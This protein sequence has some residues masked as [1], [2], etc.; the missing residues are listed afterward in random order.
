M[1][2]KLGRWLRTAGY[3]TRIADIGMTDRQVMDQAVNEQR[4]LITRD[5]KMQEYREARHTVVLLD[6]AEMDD[7]IEEVTQKLKINW[8]LKPFSRC[9]KCN[10]EL[11]E[12]HPD[13][14]TQLPEEVQNSTQL[15]CYCP[16]CDQLY[17]EGAHVKR[18]YRQL[19]RYARILRND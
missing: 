18:M 10:T 4:L 9:L 19:Q 6:C 14:A 12:V 16:H 2:I 3:D 7:C 11:V 5:R 17:W 15:A 13:Q 8:L 1:L